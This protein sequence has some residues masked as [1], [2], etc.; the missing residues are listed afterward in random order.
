M[1]FS[2]CVVVGCLSCHRVLAL[3]S[4]SSL[5]IG[6]FSWH[7]V[8]SSG[9]SSAMLPR[10]SIQCAYCHQLVPQA[11]GHQ[12]PHGWWYCD[13]C[14]AM[15]DRWWSA[16]LDAC[17]MLASKRWVSRHGLLCVDVYGCLGNTTQQIVAQHNI[18]WRKITN[19]WHIGIWH[20]TQGDM[21]KMRCMHTR[22]WDNA[23]L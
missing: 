11:Q 22:S 20:M 12:C 1:Q 7:W 8:R 13:A 21:L 10:I 18:S 16:W 23:M 19:I 3:S 6:F 14:W 4:G 9:S 2:S 17:V 15:W 5:V